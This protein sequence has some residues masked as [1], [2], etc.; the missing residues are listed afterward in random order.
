MTPVRQP[1]G[2]T[3]TSL[4]RWYRVLWALDVGWEQVTEAET[5]ALVGWLRHARNPQRQRRHFGSHP[6][7]SVNP[8]TGKPT[9]RAGYAPST[10]AHN[11][12]VVHG[13]YA[14]HQSLVAVHWSTQSRKARPAARHWPT[15]RRWRSANRPAHSRRSLGYWVASAW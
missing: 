7:G 14:F 12:T 15:G 10:I 1:A 11:L 2:A 4:L 6:A 5:A 8:K 9:L 3:A 13:F